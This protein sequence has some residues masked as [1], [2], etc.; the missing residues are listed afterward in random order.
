MNE[1]DVKNKHVDNEITNLEQLIKIIYEIEQD[2]IK[3]NNGYLFRGQADSDWKLESSWWRDYKESHKNEDEDNKN[4]IIIDAFRKMEEQISKKWGYERKALE[5]LGEVQHYNDVHAPTFLIDFTSNIYHALW[6]AFADN[7]F[8]KE[9]LSK[10]ARIYILKYKILNDDDDTNIKYEMD[11]ENLKDKGINNIYAL[12]PSHIIQRSNAQKSYFICDQLFKKNKNIIETKVFTIKSWKISHKIKKDIIQYLNK[13][14]ITAKSIYPDLLGA[15]KDAFAY[16]KKDKN[17]K[18]SY[19]LSKNKKIGHKVNDINIDNDN[20]FNLLTKKIDHL[21]ILI[22]KNTND[23][24]A[25]YNRGNVYLDKNEL[26]KAIDDYTKAV[27]IDDGYKEAY[28]NRGDAYF[29]KNEWDKAIEDYTKAI[30]IDDGYK[31][32]YFNLGNTYFRKNELDKA[33]EDY[34]KAI[35]IDN[36]YKE[37]YYNRGVAYGKMNKLDEAIADFTKAIEIDDGYKE[38]Y[39]GR[40]VAYGKMNKLDEAI[41]DFTKAIEIDDGYKNAYHNRG[42]AYEKINKFD[43]AIADFTKAIE[44][45]DGYE[46]AYIIGEL[47]IERWIN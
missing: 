30:E 16:V 21:S 26:D 11:I 1:N 37:A 47:F 9:Y 43:K 8:N 35:E 23:K 15:Y 32:A 42:V 28:V 2:I 22:P 13:K 45:D 39:N 10:N 12:S 25:Y 18:N 20:L 40:G 36:R 38:A 6:F 34:T 27:E 41:A 5:I 44:I 31:E 33:I 46:E 19:W 4:N 7:P 17:E 3:S 24:E 29:D 14:G